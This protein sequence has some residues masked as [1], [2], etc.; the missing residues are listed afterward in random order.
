MKD[1]G[2]R[3]PQQRCICHQ[4]K[5]KKK[6][7]DRH[8]FNLVASLSEEEYDE[9]R[10]NEGPTYPNQMHDHILHLYPPVFFPR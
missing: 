6:K 5:K 10:A 7:S 1:L 2:A 8:T 3:N 9:G 4:D